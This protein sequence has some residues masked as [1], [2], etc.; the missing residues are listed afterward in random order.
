MFQFVARVRLTDNYWRY[1][2]YVSGRIKRKVA[3]ESECFAAKCGA[4]ETDD[5]Y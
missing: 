2:R 5:C 1:M 3:N 4:L